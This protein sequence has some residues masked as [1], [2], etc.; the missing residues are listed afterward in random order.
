MININTTALVSSV[1]KIRVDDF[2]N[3]SKNE[4]KLRQKANEFEAIFIKHMLDQAM[5]PKSGLLPQGA[6]AD[7]YASMY[8]DTLSKQM[9]GSIGLG[10][11]VFEYLREQNK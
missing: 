9:S 6:G 8:T 10:K 11:M 1:P 4:K 2:N 5:K 3:L 7:I